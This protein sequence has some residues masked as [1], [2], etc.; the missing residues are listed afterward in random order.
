MSEKAE[1]SFKEFELHGWQGCVDA[2]DRAFTALTSQAG[3]ALVRQ[4]GIA[5]GAYVLDC[6]CGPGSLTALIASLG[7]HAIGI[8]FSPNMISRARRLHPDLD[9][10]VQDAEALE[11]PA[12]TFD[13]VTMNFGM[14]HLSDPE[15]ATAEAARVLKRSGGFGFVV[16]APPTEAR[17]FQVILD[18]IVRYGSS[19]VTLPPGPPFFK[20]SD[21]SE[22]E[23]IL[24]GAGLS[25][26]R[27]VKLPL[28]WHFSS[29]EELFEAFLC[30][31]ARTGGV[32]RAQPKENLAR[33]KHAVLMAA[34]EQFGRAEDGGLEIP[35][36]CML[37]TAIK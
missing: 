9:L 16:W 25:R 37:Y 1:G 34:R 11:F 36:P 14:L 21:A 5:H 12:D 27:T 2:Y 26:V 17:G 33:I 8:D 6:A 35:M 3:E 31:T 30:G 13:F 28:A 7:A 24:L 10:R 18:A 20:Y 32:L 29:P 15:R 22:G 4:L 19:A 23:A